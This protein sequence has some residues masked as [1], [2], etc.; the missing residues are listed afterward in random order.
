MRLPPALTIV[1]PSYQEAANLPVLIPRLADALGD[2]A[3]EVM[4]VDDDSPD[5]GAALVKAWAARDP[6]IRCIRRVGRRGLS[7][8]CIEGILASAAPVVAVMDADL[9][10][11]ETLLPAMR[12]AI[13]S[14]ADLVIASRYLAG[15]AA[16]QGFGGTRAFASRLAT[17]YTRRILR[18]D[19]TD[20]LSGFFMLRRQVV[21]GMAARLSPDGFKLLSDILALAPP[22]LVVRELPYGFRP[23]VAG[24][25]KLDT[26]VALDFVAMTVTRATGDLLP[27]RFILFG[28]VG[29]LGIVVH[30][31]ALEL[32]LEGIGAAFLPAQIAATLAAMI[33]NFI[34]NNQVTYRDQRLRG[35]RFWVGM[36]AF[37]AVCSMGALA[38]ISAATALQRLDSAPLLAG[39]CGALMSA[40]FNYSV[41]RA[42][43]WRGR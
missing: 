23:R 34:L 11:D 22:G 6:R 25:S 33:S 37:A 20:P 2:I 21:E 28:A 29:A 10:H 35:R 16:W 32:L 12:E 30:L 14:G 15:A 3:W 1:V 40:V 39:F 27:P 26:L 19:L 9:Q 36:L 42:L 5:G 18:R 8:A 41:S 24:G 43:I 31:V 4:V 17:A 13:A 7:G 38:N